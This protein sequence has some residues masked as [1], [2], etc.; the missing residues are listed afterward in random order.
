MQCHKCPHNGRFEGEAWKQ[1]PCAKC[2]L[3]HVS[4]RTR[5]FDEDGPDAAQEEVYLSQPYERLTG[6]DDDP[7][8]PLSVLGKAMACWISLTLPAREV[9]SLRM[10]DRSL[11][12]IAYILGCT[13]QS[14]AGVLERAIKENPIMASLAAGRQEHRK[15]RKRKIIRREPGL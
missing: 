14:V 5:E 15:G 11:G 12:R 1:S 10:K 3:R 2:K 8:I 6:T 4:S 13:K 9:F 7:M